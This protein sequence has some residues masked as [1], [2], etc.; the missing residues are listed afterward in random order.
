MHVIR[1]QDI[2]RAKQTE[3][4]TCVEQAKLPAMMKRIAEPAGS[5]VL[6]GESPMHRGKASV[7][8]GCKTRQI[9]L[10]MGRSLGE[11]LEPM[12]AVN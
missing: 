3:T 5:P 12:S 6:D 9:A 7:E 10:A 4:S 8:T 2:S 1:H 11:I